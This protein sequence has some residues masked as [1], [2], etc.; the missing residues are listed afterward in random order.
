MWHC[1]TVGTLTPT[2]V[3]A[4]ARQPRPGA[5]YRRTVRVAVAGGPRGISH[6]LR[7]SRGTAPFFW[8][9]IALR[10]RSA[11][12]KA[13]GHHLGARTTAQRACRVLHLELAIGP[14]EDDQGSSASLGGTV[15]RRAIGTYRNR[16]VRSWERFPASPPPLPF[17]APGV[18]VAG[19]CCE[20]RRNRN[21]LFSFPVRVRL[22]NRM[23]GQ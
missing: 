5:G 9:G 2:A 7:G 17:C 16:S 11:S 13:N 4:R 23:H 6:C 3:R 22:R 19:W 10:R 20:V 14:V 12:C 8:S 15:A 1:C 18:L 21:I